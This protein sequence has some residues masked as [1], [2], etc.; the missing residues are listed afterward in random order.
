MATS[1][2]AGLAQDDTLTKGTARTIPQR[3]PMVIVADD[4]A[5]GP[6]GW[7][8]LINGTQ[9]TG[10][11]LPSTMPTSGK[12]ALRLAIED[13][14]ASY[15]PDIYAMAVKRFT[16]P[17]DPATNE[18]RRY[19]TFELDVAIT[20]YWNTAQKW[21]SPRA[22]DI[23]LDHG[24]GAQADGSDNRTFASIRYLII[25]EANSDALVQKFQFRSD[26]GL[27]NPYV[28]IL[29]PQGN[30]I[31]YPIG[32]NENK[33]GVFT[34]KGMVD[35]QDHRLV[36]MSINGRGYGYLNLVGKP[37]G[38]QINTADKTLYN[39]GQA[40]TAPLNQGGAASFYGGLNYCV[41]LYSRNDTGNTAAD[42]FITNPRVEAVA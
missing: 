28:D 1:A 42:L 40:W 2:F 24:W 30:P 25:D 32:Y 20:S 8:G 29:D 22:I 4:F 11:V 33:G 26:N 36:G 3:D 10:V 19:L 39:L 15:N 34:L 31:T 6:C 5:D 9:A 16:L 38:T 13:G 21:A 41:E 37:A 14:G 27:P 17:Y 35:I 18:H 23:G 7:R 12:A